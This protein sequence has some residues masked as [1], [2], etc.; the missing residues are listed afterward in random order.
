MCYKTGQFYLLTTLKKEIGD[1]PRFIFLT[2]VVKKSEES[3]EKSGVEHGFPG[4]SPSIGIKRLPVY[5]SG[6]FYPA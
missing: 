2:I 6:Y 5:K 4:F 3:A 1:S